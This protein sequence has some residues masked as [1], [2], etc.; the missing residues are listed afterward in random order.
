[1]TRRAL[2][3]TANVIAMD[4]ATEVELARL[5]MVR[6]QLQQQGIRDRRV[7]EVMSRV[8][9]ERFVEVARPADAYADRALGISCGQTISQPVIVAM[10]TEALA[11]QGNETVLDVGTGSG[12]QAAILAE[13][14]ARVISIETH[15]E[16]SARA[17][18]ALAELGYRNVELVVGDGRLGWR[19]AAPYQG[20]VVAAATA[21]CPP[22]LLDQLADGGVLVIP[23][24]GPAGQVLERI[25][26]RD[27]RLHTTHLTACRFVPLVGDSAGD[28]NG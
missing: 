8:P 28:T 14:A 27:E 13:L 23:I 19:A 17:G 6:E 16:L 7:L 4:H 1:M 18:R 5:R 20:I 21:E 22:A 12:Y 15:G 25:E 11:L 9:R 26:R 3:A 24:G 10:M 2:N